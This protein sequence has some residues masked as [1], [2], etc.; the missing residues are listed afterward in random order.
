MTWDAANNRWLQAGT[1]CI[2]ANSW[3]HP[4]VN[5]SVKKWVAPASGTVV[6]RASGNISVGSG[7]GADGVRVK[8]LKNSSNIWPASGWQTISAGGSVSFPQQTVTVNAGDA[9]Y[10]I[11]NRNGNASFDTT[12][13]EPVIEYR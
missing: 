12:Q 5:D 7:T 1:S 10:F 9:L 6:I 3:Q 2:A 11:V 13:W 8:V 4:D